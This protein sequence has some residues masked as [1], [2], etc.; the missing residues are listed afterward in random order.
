MRN[1]AKSYPFQ[2][3]RHRIYIPFLNLIDRIKDFAR[4]VDTQKYIEL[5]TVGL[6]PN[7]GVR[8]ETISYCKLKKILKF[9]KENHHNTFIDIGCGLGRALIVAHEIGFKHLYGVDISESFINI[10]RTNLQTQSCN[11]DLLISDISNYEP[12]SGRICIYMFNPFGEKKMK[13]FLA[14]INNRQ[15]DTLI[16]YHNPKYS[17]LFNSDYLIKKFTWHNF[18]LYEEKCHI[19]LVSGKGNS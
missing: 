1:L 15:D 18:G 9:A 6:D 8:Y 14:K 2:V 19:Y 12:P 16:V 13:E 10:C 11:A 7:L 3:F 4:R 17:Y 5:E